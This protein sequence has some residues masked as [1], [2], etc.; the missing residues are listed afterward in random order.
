MDF[1]DHRMKIKENEKI[2]KY[3]DLAWELKNVEHEGDIDSHCSWSA[4]NGS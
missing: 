1:A 2:D 3:F 4:W